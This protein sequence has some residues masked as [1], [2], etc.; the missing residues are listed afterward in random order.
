MFDLQTV[1]EDRHCRRASMLFNS[2]T[3]VVFLGV[4]FALHY[5]NRRAF[6]QVGVLTVAS[7]VFYGWHTP[8]LVFL[9]ILSTAVNA[10]AA[11]WLM[12]EGWSPQRRRAVLF[13]ALGFNV[14][15]LA[16]FK[17]FGLLVTTLVPE[18]LR[19]R[20][21]A[22]FSE[23]PLPIGISFYTFQGISLVVESWHAGTK[24]FPG[25]MPPRGP[26]EVGWFHARVWFFKAFFPQLIAGPIVKAADFF[27]QIG[28][29]RWADVDWSGALR[30]LVLGFFLKMVVADNLKEATALL[31]H[32]G[33][34]EVPRLNL[35]LLLYGFSF[36]IFADF[37]GYSFIA[38]G[39]AKL[40]GYELPLNF[41]H[42]YLSTSLTEFWRRWHLSL[43][44][45][46]REYLYIPLGGNRRGEVRTYIN[47]FLVMFLGGLWHGAA[48]S[49][50]AWGTAHGLCLA[51]ERLTGIGRAD[52]TRLP[53][54]RRV[55][56]MVVTFHVVSLLWLLFQFPDIRHAGAYVRC[57]FTNPGGALPQSI[58]VI[59]VF[60]LPAVLYHAWGASRGWRGRMGP[61]WSG[62]VEAFVYGVLLFL[63]LVNAGASGDF[64]YFQF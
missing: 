35:W 1:G 23:V 60:C 4:V 42:P 33:F 43:S 37:A 13:G 51:L 55:V 24:G 26:K 61:L 19:A 3:F 56:G 57:L 52:P 20:M 58:F 5:A 46:L 36:Q 18:A 44:S 48:W 45:W 17:Y 9:L 50:A 14:G 59:A 39:L 27:H 16:F 53:L 64:I 41:D 49:Y 28:P 40:F 30:K 54:W 32:P 10:Q 8:W 15:A 2:W 34:L 6:W 38:Q 63:I 12:A 22:W 47:L 21:P 7:F 11:Q 29:K 62:R 31:S 25:L